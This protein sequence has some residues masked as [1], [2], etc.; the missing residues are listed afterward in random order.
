MTNLLIYEYLPIDLIYKIE[1][2]IHMINMKPIFNIINKYIPRYELKKHFYLQYNGLKTNY[3]NPSHITLSLPNNQ[4]FIR[5]NNINKIEN[6]CIYW[7][8]NRNRFICESNY[9]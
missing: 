3:K 1:K 6:R 4:Y 7:L 9:Y 5:K 2:Y 8:L